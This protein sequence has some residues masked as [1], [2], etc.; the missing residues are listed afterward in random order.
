ALVLQH[1]GHA[2]IGFH[3]VVHAVAHHV[4]VE[5]VLVADGDEQPDG[6]PGA[7]GNERLVKSPGAVGHLGIERPLLVHERTRRGQHAVVK[8]GTEPGHDERGRAAGTVTH[9]RAAVGVFGQLH[10]VVLLHARQHFGFDVLGVVA[11]HVVVFLAALVALGVAA[12]VG[13]PDDN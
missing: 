12:A 3:P 10:L 11:V 8:I 5:Q 4:G 6:F 9:D 7:V 2:V 13:N 1:L